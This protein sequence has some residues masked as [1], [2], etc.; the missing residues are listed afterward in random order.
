MKKLSLLIIFLTI[1]F[2]LRAQPGI[3]CLR[4]SDGLLYSQKNVFGYY[5]L[6]GNKYPTAPP[7]CPRVQ[8]GTKTGAKCLFV[9]SGPLNDEYNYVLYTATGPVQCDFDD[10]AFASMIVFAVIGCRKLI[11]L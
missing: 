10:Y 1:Y 2:H 6:L 5:E 7:A 3:G 4:S 8:L 11:K 9:L